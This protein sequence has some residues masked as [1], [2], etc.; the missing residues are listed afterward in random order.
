MGLEPMQSNMNKYFYF[1]RNW[2]LIACHEPVFH[3]LTILKGSET[4]IRMIEVSIAQ[5]RK[6]CQNSVLNMVQYKSSICLEYHWIIIEII[7]PRSQK[8]GHKRSS[9]KKNIISSCV[10]PFASNPT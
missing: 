1:L 10:L 2:W 4:L 3:S 8:L 5:M 7:C 9:K 6:E